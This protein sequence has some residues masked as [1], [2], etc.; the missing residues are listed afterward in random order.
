MARKRNISNGAIFEEVQALS[1]SHTRAQ[2][3]EILRTLIDRIDVRPLKNGHEILLTGDIVK[4]ITLPDGS[5]VP[6]PFHC[7][8]SGPRHR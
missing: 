4:M 2:A 5:S 3:S 1:D 8:V 7:S 6:D